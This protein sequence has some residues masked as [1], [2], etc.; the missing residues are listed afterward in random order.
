MFE[1]KKGDIWNFLQIF[2]PK[3]KS[4]QYVNFFFFYIA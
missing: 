4:E 1:I 3:E 2:G